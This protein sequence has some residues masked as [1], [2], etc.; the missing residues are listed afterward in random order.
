MVEI[1]SWTLAAVAATGLAAGLAHALSGPDHLAAVTPLVVARRRGG[2]AVGAV[3][4]LGHAC[5]VWVLGFLL[6]LLRDM[7][8]LDAISS[9]SERL[10]GIALIALGLWGFRKVL[11]GWV[12]THEH[13]HDGARHVH[14]HMHWP[15]ASH[16]PSRVDGH[17]RAGIHSHAAMGIG[18]LHGL[19]GGSNLLGILPS[20]VLPSVVQ[21][22]AYLI[23]F[24][25]G[26]IV[27]MAAFSRAVGLLADG[28]S[29]ARING[30]RWLLGGSSAAAVTVGCFWLLL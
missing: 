15:G 22:A 6:V 11:A 23:A 30:G 3:W 4:G 28:L 10:V 25:I 2:W 5:G 13:G 16:P 9:W 29:G 19:A 14:V 27:G 1:G 18:V 21:A 8:P 24:G 17:P 7:L 12:H 26:S 20:L